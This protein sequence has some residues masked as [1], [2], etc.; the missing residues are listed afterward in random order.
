MSEADVTYYLPIP[1]THAHRDKPT[2]ADWY[3]HESAFAT[4]L[5][6]RGF[7]HLC[8]QRPFRWTTDLNGH[9]FWRRWFGKASTSRDWFVGGDNLYAYLQP[10]VIGHVVPL[11]RTNLIAHSHGLQVVLFAAAM[12][13]KLRTLVSLGSPVRADLDA[14]AV[15][16]KKNIGH[17]THVYS[18]HDD[19]MQ[20][21]GEIGDGVFGIKRQ[22]PRADRNVFIPGVAHSRLLNDP[23]FFSYWE[24]AG[25][26]DDLRA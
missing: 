17:W 13:C 2:K 4:F 21:F 22:H 1:G 8:P 23:T 14:I 7:V 9:R 3:H 10:P 26:M 12:G 25:L 16:A 6:A 11:E 18:D 15:E 24:H 20:W 19:R 5:S